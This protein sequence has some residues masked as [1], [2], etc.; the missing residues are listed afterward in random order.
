MPE[1]FASPVA[2]KRWAELSPIV[3]SPQH[4]LLRVYCATYAEWDNAQRQI[5][6]LGEI[7]KNT[8]GQVVI[9]PWITI[10]NNAAT[11]LQRLSKDLGIVD[12]DPILPPEFNEGADGADA[13][14]R[15]IY[16]DE[17]IIA[18]LR[19]TGGIVSE[20]ARVLRISRQTF[21]VNY[22]SRPAVQAYLPIIREDTTDLAE[23][24]LLRLIKAG[25]KDAI[26]YY[27][28]CFGKSRGYI[29]QTRTEHT[30]EDGGPIKTQNAHIDMSAEKFDELARQVLA[31]I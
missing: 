18:L 17:E 10:R 11:T 5:D 20:A 2:A 13:R 16:S 6:T 23:G 22:M 25:D 7:V 29:E 15:K 14:A 8:Q 24:Q 31:K 3:P 27:M 28:R 21:Y 19:K 30:G 9:S 26:R 4:D 1:Q 12:D